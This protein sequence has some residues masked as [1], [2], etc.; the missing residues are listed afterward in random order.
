MLIRPPA[1]DTTAAACVAAREQMFAACDGEL[2]LDQTS[3]LDVHLVHC[4]ECRSR[5]TA[6][7][8]FHRAVRHAVSGEVAPPSLRDRI[9]LSLT[10]RSTENAP[11]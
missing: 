5:F 7:I 1:H 6:D 11:A 10:T 8:T 9:L 4:A 2:T 3:S